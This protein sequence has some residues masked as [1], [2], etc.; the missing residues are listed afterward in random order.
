MFESYESDFTSGVSYLKTDFQTYDRATNDAEKKTTLEAMKKKLTECESKIKMMENE[1]S[2]TGGPSLMNK[3]RRHRNEYDDLKKKLMQ[4]ENTF[5]D[6]VQKK[7]LF[8]NRNGKGPDAPVDPRGRV[9]QTNEKLYNQNKTMNEMDRTANE[10]DSRTNEINKELYRQRGVIETG[11][12][13]NQEIGKELNRTNYMEDQ[14]SRREC[15]NKSLLWMTVLIL[16]TTNIFLLTR[17]LIQ[18]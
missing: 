2:F 6:K 13:E 12:N 4:T 7:E 15:I 8:G 3:I 18:S 9:I 16:I 14:I 5:M 11:I 17:K 10:I 1:A